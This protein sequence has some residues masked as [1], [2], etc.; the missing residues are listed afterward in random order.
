MPTD[1]PALSLLSVISLISFFIVLLISKFSIKI[2]NGNL[3]DQD[4][5]KPQAFHSEPIARCGGLA[6]FL[7]LIIFFILYYLLFKEILFNYAALSTTFFLIGFLEDLR[8]KISP[9]YRLILMILSLLFFIFIFSIS[10]ESVDLNFLSILLENSIF[11]ILFVLLCFLFIINGSNLVDGFNGLLIIH[12]LIINSILLFINLNN[13][14]EALMLIIAAQIVILLPLLL[15]NFPQ[16]KIFLGDGG[17]YLFGS[18]VAL[19]IIETNNLNPQISSFFF[20]I[21]LFYLFFEV[22]FSFFRKIYSK[23]S[24]L[25][26]DRFHLH[27]LS[28]NFLKKSQKF[29]DCNYLNSLI[30]NVIY[31]SLILPVIYFNDN[32]LICRYWFFSLLVLYI[33]FYYIFYSFEKKQ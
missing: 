30:I 14:H 29:K 13:N 25:K 1:S 17:S 18:L 26:P 12:L 23:K 2:K 10:I 33:I 20:C 24:P 19:N 6:G 21:L 3:L 11:S 7:S 16:A 22:F 8:F 27:M 32:G 15:F 28:Y 4:F 31:V 9:N 5:E